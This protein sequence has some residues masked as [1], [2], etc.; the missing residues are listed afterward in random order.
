V[1]LS[2][3]KRVGDSLECAYHGLQFGADGSCTLAPNDE[4][5]QRVRMC[6][7]AYHAVERDSLIWLWMGDKALADPT[8]IPEFGFFVD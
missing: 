4:E 7:R 6:V 8:K 2:M 1:P 5:Q 3:G